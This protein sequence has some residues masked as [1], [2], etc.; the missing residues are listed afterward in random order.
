MTINKTVL[1]LLFSITAIIASGFC[2]YLGEQLNLFQINKTMLLIGAVLFAIFTRQAWIALEKNPGLQNRTDSKK[3]LA[4]FLLTSMVFI[5]LSM[6]L[7]F[8]LVSSI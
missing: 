2:V 6:T 8:W 7:F 1:R 4:Y 5:P 3:R